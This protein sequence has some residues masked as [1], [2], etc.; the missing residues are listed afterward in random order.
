[1]NHP[2]RATDVCTS[3]EAAHHLIASC[4]QAVQ[5]D[6][7][8]K[9]VQQ[10]LGLT[11]MEL[12]RA[13]GHDRYMLARRLPELLEGGRAWR[14]PKKP[15]EVSGRSACTWWPVAPGDNYALAV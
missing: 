15:C 2:A 6:R 9:A 12:A 1:M 4:Q 8:A 10:H 14:R 13:T 3:H 7:A 11:S 5:Q